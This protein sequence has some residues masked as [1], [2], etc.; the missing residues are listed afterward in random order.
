MAYIAPDGY[1]VYLRV[2]SRDPKTGK[3]D[4][5][6][7]SQLD[8]PPGH[9]GLQYV[10]LCWNHLGN[11]LAVVDASGHVLFFLYDFALNRLAFVRVE[12]AQPGEIGRASCRERVF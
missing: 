9:D 5:S 11:Q 12:V 4:L 6:K 2:F 7:D 10:H 3:W 1:A 8:F